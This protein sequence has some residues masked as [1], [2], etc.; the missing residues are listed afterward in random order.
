MRTKNSDVPMHAA[1][2][3]SSKNGQ[4]LSAAAAANTN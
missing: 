3:D 2:E 1:F 4:L